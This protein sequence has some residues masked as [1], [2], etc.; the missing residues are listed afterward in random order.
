[1]RVVTG[2]PAA[3]Q[4]VITDENRNPVAPD[5][6][7][8][9]TVTVARGDLSVLVQGDADDAGGGTVTFTLPAQD[10]CDRLVAT[11]TA[12]VDGAVRTERAVVDVV[13]CRILPDDYLSDDATL[14]RLT[15]DRLDRV[16]S[17]V[18]VGFRDIIGTPVVPEGARSTWWH[19]SSWGAGG[20]ADGPPTVTGV[21][22]G[23]G[24]SGGRL[25]LPGISDPL[26]VYSLSINGAT[27]STPD[28]ALLGFE[29][30]ALQWGDGRGFLAGRYQAW[31]A[32]GLAYPEAD[33]VDAALTMARYLARRIPRAGKSSPSL[34]PER[35]ASYTSEGAT[36]VF[37]RPGSDQPT[38]LPEVD[39]VLVR[40][41]SDRVI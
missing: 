28:V 12:T 22:Y 33:L 17:S 9:L 1:M 36:I 21:P 18:E 31:L 5:P 35:T 40:Y 34:L 30:G 10:R 4:W 3:L 13:G 6:G 27:L 37:A 8:P 26:E 20:M 16:L 14:G 25:R 38:G 32:H 29:S 39:G 2:R 11:L 23:V 41:M 7:E 19:R 15:P 24:I